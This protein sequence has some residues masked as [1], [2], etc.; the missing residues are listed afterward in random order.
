[1]LHAF[2]KNKFPVR[3]FKYH[4]LLYLQHTGQTYTG[5]LQ[6]AYGG[7]GR[8][9]AGNQL[10]GQW[11]RGNFKTQPPVDHKTQQHMLCACAAQLMVDWFKVVLKRDHGGMRS[12]STRATLCPAPLWTSSGHC[13]CLKQLKLARTAGQLVVGF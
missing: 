12:P 13:H 4:M 7:V 5:S 11:L 1:M 2:A 10:R 3:T 6:Q 8:N 9:I